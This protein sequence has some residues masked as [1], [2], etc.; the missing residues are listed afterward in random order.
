MNPWKTDPQASEAAT[1]LSILSC[2]HQQVSFAICGLWFDHAR[3][4]VRTLPTRDSVV[5]WFDI[6]GGGVQDSNADQMLATPYINC[7]PVFYVCS[8]P[9]SQESTDRASTSTLANQNI[10]SFQL[11]SL[12]LHIL[13]NHPQPLSGHC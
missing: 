4:K 8:V 6:N 3:Q 5:G 10:C 13:A 2:M 11:P 7:L 1:G 12:V 9:S